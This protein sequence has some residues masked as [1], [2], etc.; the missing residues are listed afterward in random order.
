MPGVDQ[1]VNRVLRT[2]LLATTIAGG[3]SL[4]STLAADCAGPGQV[5]KLNSIIRG[6]IGNLKEKEE[7]AVRTE[8]EW[9]ALWIKLGLPLRPAVA[10][11]AVDF[12]KDMVLGVSAGE[13]RGVV[14]LEIT[15][16][17]RKTGC[18][19][20][21]VTE[22]AVPPKMSPAQFVAFHPFHFVRVSAAPGTVV[23]TFARR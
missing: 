20:V 16:V 5:V 8:A 10:A 6:V 19:L 3:T 15:K 1:R 17:E 4:P 9:K 2:A 13:G 21:T 18:V 11:P 7:L 12:S 22:R 14:E 23:F